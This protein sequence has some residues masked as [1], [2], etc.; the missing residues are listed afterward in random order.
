M[1]GGGLVTHAPQWKQRVPRDTGAGWDFEDIRDHY[2]HELYGVEAMPLRASDPLRYQ[3]LSR[4]V[5]G[6][7]M[8]RAFAEWR[9]AA[10]SNG[11][12]L[13]WFYKDLWPAAGWGVLDSYG[14][15]KPTY[16]YL[17]RA[18]QSQQLTITDEGL[19]GLRL[20]IINESAT[21]SDVIIEITLLK[22]PRQTVLRE[23]CPISLRGRETRSLNVNELLG[24]FCDVNYAY[25][26]GPAAH[27]VVIATLMDARRNVVSEAF[28]FLRRENPAFLAG[29]T[30][31]AALNPID[32]Q[33]WQLELDA[34]AFLQT[35]RL[36]AKGFQPSDNY[37]HLT[38]QRRKSV[39]FRA[40][41]QLPR[42]IKVDVEALNV[43][44]TMTVIPQPTTTTAKA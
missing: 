2:L 1:D 9:S 5:P 3:Q 8:S 17:K 27:D 37:F 44:G 6:E 36:S 41:D 7:M 12:G 23:E 21:D 11:G 31:T 28:Y 43:D 18:W 39:R 24:R 25:R 20:H 22:Q 4:T 13:V 32:S 40:L 35:V 16:Y 29:H 42:G 38:P 19:S 10:S 15:P 30:L 26:F 34:D 33:T 14:Q